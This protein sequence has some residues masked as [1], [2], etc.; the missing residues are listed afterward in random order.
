VRQAEAAQPRFNFGDITL[1][2]FARLTGRINDKVTAEGPNTRVDAVDA[3]TGA[4]ARITADQI[5]A[6][7]KNRQVERIDAVGSVE[8]QGQ[9]PAVDR[10]GLQKLEGSGTRG[11]YYKLEGRLVLEGPVK[12]YAEQPPASGAGR[13]SVQGTAAQAVYD[14]KK[15][16]LVLSG[17]VHAKV[18][19]T[20][21]LGPEGSDVVSDVVEID[22]STSPYTFRLRSSGGDS[23]VRVRPKTKE[24]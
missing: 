18:L 3:K 11:T 9:R 7:M 5:I 2:G 13:Q 14:E 1:T 22:M 6:T 19:D 8:F 21:N 12:F 15:L 20:E 10:K 4:R 17:N 24:E 23:Q 16:L